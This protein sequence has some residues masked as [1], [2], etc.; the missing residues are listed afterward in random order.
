MGTVKGRL[1]DRL[2]LTGAAFLA[3][4]VGLASFALAARYHL[5]KSWIFALWTGLG[6]IWVIGRR[7]RAL[8][9]R[10]L[11]FLYLVGWLVIHTAGSVWALFNC[12]LPGLWEF[13]LL[14]LFLGFLG[15]HLLFVRGGQNKR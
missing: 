7:Y 6:F 14:E 8:L 3:T 9:R 1:F 4:G 13:T 10:P 12:G 15:V 5:P 11:F 2:L